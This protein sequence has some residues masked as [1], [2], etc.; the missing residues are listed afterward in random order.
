LGLPPWTEARI[1]TAEADPLG[2][3][4]FRSGYTPYHPRGL[5][6]ILKRRVAAG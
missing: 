4:V 1:P 5:L 2:N 3:E 6:L